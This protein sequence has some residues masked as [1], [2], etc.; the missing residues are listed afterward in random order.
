M[1]ANDVWQRQTNQFGHE[2]RLGTRRGKASIHLPRRSFCQRFLVAPADN[3]LSMTIV[4]YPAID[5]DCRHQVFIEH[6]TMV[7]RVDLPAIGRVDVSQQFVGQVGG[8]LSFEYVVLLRA[9][10]DS[11]FGLSSVTAELIDLTAQTHISL[12][13]RSVTSSGAPGDKRDASRSRESLSIPIGASG[14]YALRLSTSVDPECSGSSAHLLIDSVRVCDFS[15]TTVA[16]L[17]SVSCVG[18]SD[19]SLARKVLPAM[20]KQRR[21]RRFVNSSLPESCQQITHLGTVWLG[22]S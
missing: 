18:A 22:V 8:Q 7:K 3:I 21:K 6:G 1:C 10:Q 17:A 19:R 16:Q 12:I 4:G 20:Q 2:V 14:P 9:R 11:C 15:G 5:S 13:N